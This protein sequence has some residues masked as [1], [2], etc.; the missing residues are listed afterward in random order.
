VSPTLQT[1]IGTSYVPDAF[2]AAGTAIEFA[3]KDK[4][5]PATVCAL[6][7]YKRAKK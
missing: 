1:N 2:A 3:I 6:P 5:E 4:R 7:F